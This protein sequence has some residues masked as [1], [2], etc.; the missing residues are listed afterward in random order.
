MSPYQWDAQD[1]EKNSAQQRL[2]AQELIRKLELRGDEAVLDVG[3]GDG[4][5]SAEIAAS[6]PAGR[7]VGIDLS[8]EMIALAQARFPAADYPNLRFQPA[9]ASRL[10][11][12]GEFDVV[13]S[14]ATLHWLRDH[15]PALQGIAKSLKPGG[16]ILLQ[17]GG[18]GNAAGIVAAIEEL[19]SQPDWLPYFTGFDFPYGFYAPPEYQGW[20]LAAGLL[21]TRLELIP[22]DML[23]P[24][25]AGLAG[26]LRTTWLPY[27][28]RLPEEKRS[29]FIDTLVETYT[30]VNP[31]D[32]QGSVHVS[33]V[34]LE[35]E[36]VKPPRST[37]KTT[38]A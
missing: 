1:Y 10:P 27:T 7:V 13:F 11:F 20:L 23:H 22:K 8:G 28:Q 6:V 21:P 17:M 9:D 36:A 14:N 25:K 38:P 12:A 19:I 4:K 29:A 34:R 33:M 3:C 24:G 2:W 16:K 31:V 5:V 35:V 26:W 30:A 15:R 37:S 18:K 32:D